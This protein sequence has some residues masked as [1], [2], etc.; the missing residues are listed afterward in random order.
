VA[1]GFPIAEATKERV[2]APERQS[3][4]QTSQA[5]LG[6]RLSSALVRVRGR[7]PLKAW[8]RREP[9]TPVDAK[10]CQLCKGPIRLLYNMKCKTIVV[11]GLGEV[12]KPLLDLVSERHEATGVDIEP[13][14]IT[15]GIDVL[16]VCFPY[17]IPDFVG[18]CSRYIDLYQPK[19]T[20]INSTVGVGT[21]RAVAERTGVHV[22]NSPI[23]G[24]HARMLE[25][26]RVYVK[27]IGAL[28]SEAADLAVDHFESVG[29]K[30]KV[31]S[32]PEASELAK[33]TETT[34]FGVLI[35][36]AQEVERYCDLTGASYDD[37]VSFYDEINYLPRVKFFPGIVGG[38]CV[39]PNIEILEQLTHSR[40][41]DAIRASN[42][43]K[44]AREALKATP[45]AARI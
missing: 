19:L 10:A 37:V 28:S 44:I 36:W 26:L 3:K 12:G 38:H 17:E 23:R 29:V 21:T 45:A 35:A 2:H 8:I 15:C 1:Q 33:L 18:E 20:V 5:I 40:L 34:Y 43:E 14:A 41:L 25:E 9:A 30:T 13:A 6:R 16:H 32:S 4:E 39:M 27:Y 42:D 7:R 31:L 24:K 22:V 11:A